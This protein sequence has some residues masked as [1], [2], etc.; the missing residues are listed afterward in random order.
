MAERS[1]RAALQAA[2]S[3]EL[4]GWPSEVLRAEPVAGAVALALDA[5]EAHR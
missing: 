1:A 3:Q 4:P 5:L 2:L